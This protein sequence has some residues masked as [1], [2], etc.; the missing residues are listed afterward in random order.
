MTIIEP[1]STDFNKYQSRIEFST[2]NS[3][4][5]SGTY[6]CYVSVAS[7]SDYLYLVDAKNENDTTTFTVISE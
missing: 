6:T 2:L 3:T 7:D 5:D 1:F 4:I